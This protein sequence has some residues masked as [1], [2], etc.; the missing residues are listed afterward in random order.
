MGD[1]MRCTN[2]CQLFV[3]DRTISRWIGAQ[4]GP[5]TMGPPCK[6]VW[7]R[8]LFWYQTIGDPVPPADSQIKQTLTFHLLSVLVNL[9]FSSSSKIAWICLWRPS[10]GVKLTFLFSSLTACLK[11]LGAKMWLELNSKCTQTHKHEKKNKNTEALPNLV[12]MSTHSSG[13]IGALQQ[14]SKP[15]C[16]FDLL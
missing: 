15:L 2:F 5:R 11:R 3:P 12:V 6:C 4:S 13:S 16:L 8:N 9:D 1:K 7:T 14:G 10:T